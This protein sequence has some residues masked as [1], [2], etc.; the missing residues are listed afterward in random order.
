[1]TMPPPN[2]CRRIRQLFLLLNSPNPNEASNAR[3]KLERML[4]KW[5]LKWED[6][7]ACISI[8]NEDDEHRA[9]EAS[10]ARAGNAATA[11]APTT[12]GGSHINVLDLILRLI[13]LHID[14]T[15]N[16]R[17]AV[18]LWILPPYFFGRFT[19]P[20]LLALLPPVR[21]C[22]KPTLLTML[23]LLCSAP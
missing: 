4:L 2:A 1:M 3:D 21:V 17:I 11:S 14:I 8:A 12:D 10:A 19:I 9:R 15:P 23:E 20:P 16:D 7:A 22:G 18:A 6:I 13:E 5:N